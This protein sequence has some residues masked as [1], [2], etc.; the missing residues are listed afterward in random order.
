ME[1]LGWALAFG[2]ALATAAGL[3]GLAAGRIPLLRV[4]AR[5]HAIAYLLA[6]LGGL[7]VGA[8]LL[9]ASVPAVDQALGFLAPPTVLIEPGPGNEDEEPERSFHESSA[10]GMSLVTASGVTMVPP[11]V[12]SSELYPCTE[13]HAD[14]GGEHFLDRD[15]DFHEDKA[16]SGHGEPLKWC[17]DC[18]NP[19]NPDTLRLVGG[20]A[21]EFENLDVLCGQCHGKIYAAWK[22][23]AYGKRVGSWNG[24]KRYFS[25]TECHDPHQPQFEA[26]RP[27]PA[28]MRPEETLR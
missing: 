18:H 15:V 13:C 6:G 5:M 26:I 11:R 20:E 12:L 23:G 19:E 10:E 24:E 16:I 8:V 17:F 21:I 28:P 7:V 27:D 25:C 22:A 9:S 2:G 4:R 3:A 1:I 14:D